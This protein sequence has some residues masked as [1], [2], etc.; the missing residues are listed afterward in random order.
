MRDLL[1]PILVLSPM[2]GGALALILRGRAA[3]SALVALSAAALVFAAVALASNG[4]MRYTPGPLT[5]IDWN[6][7]VLAADVVLLGWFLALAWTRRHP[8]AFSLALLQAVGF[9]FLEIRYG[10]RLRVTQGF[11]VDWLAIAMVLLVSILGS[12]IAL[13]AIPYMDE[14][15]RHHPGVPSRQPRFFALILVFLGAMNGLALSNNLYWTYLFWEI[16]TLC[17]VLLIAHDGTAEAVASSNRALW[18]NL[19][20]GCAFL[21]AI[22]MLAHAQPI[23]EAMAIDRLVGGPTPYLVPVALLCLA[24]FTKSAQLPFQGWLLGAM[25]APTPVSA[26]LHSSTMV[27]AGVY[28][29]IRCAPAMQDT[30]LTNVVA[31]AGAFTF[32]ATAMVAISQR[33]AKRVLAYSTISNLGLIIACAGLNTAMA[34]SAAVMLLLFHAVSKALLFLAAGAIEQRIGSREIERMEGLVLRMPW[35]TALT[36][37]GVLTMLLPPFGVLVSKWAALE[38]AAREPAAMVLFVLGSAFTVLFWVRW[39]G[40]LMAVEPGRE[41]EMT[42]QMPALFRWTMGSVAAL[43]VL[44]SLLVTQVMQRFVAPVVASYLQVGS[45]GFRATVADLESRIGSFP[46]LGLALS[47]LIAVALAVILASGRRAPT[48][49]YLCGEPPA[50]GAELAPLGPGDRPAPVR[51]SGTYLERF[52]AEERHAAWM[53]VGGVLLTAAMLGVAAL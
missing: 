15:E 33:N 13:Y 30:G 38:S 8:G 21:A 40:R 45:E 16:T 24:G 27:K 28:L 26:L 3:R 37:L 20:G 14:H 46:V 34:V 53:T 4:L 43:A 17:C 25:V 23:G 44:L 5:T 19:V 31:L 48:V 29:V 49:P 10:E 1:I 36:V 6:R 18:M 50:E 22:L 7:V 9:A 32:V 35:T 47:L 2:A 12:A 39:I 11:V 41:P 52:F 51:V 42:E